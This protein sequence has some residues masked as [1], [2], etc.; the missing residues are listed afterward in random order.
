LGAVIREAQARHLIS[1]DHFTVD[2]TLLQAWASIKSYRPKD[3]EPPS[4]P[5][6]RNQDVDFKGERR[7]RDTHA[8]TTDPEALLFRKAANDAAK[9]CFAGHVMTENRYGLVV[10]ALLTQATGGVEREAATTMLDRKKGRKKGVTLGADKG[11][12]TADMVAALAE[13]DVVP[14]IA[15]NTSRRRSAVPD[16]T[17]QSSGYAT[18]QRRRKLVE[19]VFGWMKTVGGVRKL[20]YVG[21]AKN[22]QCF[23]FTAALYNIVRMV[24]LTKAGIGVAPAA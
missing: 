3:E 5:G 23:T 12:D 1:E 17:A 16:E 14:H 21:L 24:S 18:S 15:Q 2:G 22:E 8:S 19:E 4:G 6:G 7:S 10:D 13:R 11:Y 20:R 9:L